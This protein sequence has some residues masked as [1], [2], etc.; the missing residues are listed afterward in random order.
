MTLRFLKCTCILT[1]LIKIDIIY[2]YCVRFKIIRD[3]IILSK[4]IKDSTHN[5]MSNLCKTLLKTSM[6]RD[7]LNLICT[8]KT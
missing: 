8:G 4:I 7:T 1:I 3:K 6:L 5:T 2:I